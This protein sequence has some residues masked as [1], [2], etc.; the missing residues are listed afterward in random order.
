MT[1]SDRVARWLVDHA[2]SWLEHGHPDWAQALRAEIDAVPPGQ[3]LRV[4]AG[5]LAA[6]ARLSRPRPLTMLTLAAGIAAVVAADQSSAEAANQVTMLALLAASAI[7][8]A[9][10][11]RAWP[12]PAVLIGASIPVAHLLAIASGH[13]AAFPQHPAGYTGALS[14]FV[15]IVPAAIAALVGSHLARRARPPR[16]P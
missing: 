4:A 3:R 10:A 12:L 7:T 2:A 14:L 9:R 5:M 16:T 8:G 1:P 13:P 6:A 11:G 15:L